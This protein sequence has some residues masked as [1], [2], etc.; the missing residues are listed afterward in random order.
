MN[1]FLLLLWVKFVVG[2]NLIERSHNAPLPVSPMFSF[3]QYLIPLLLIVGLCLVNLNEFTDCSRNGLRNSTVSTH[4]HNY[5]FI[6]NIQF[7]HR[8]Y[9]K[10]KIPQQ[11]RRSP[12]QKILC[13]IYKVYVLPICNQ[14]LEKD[15]LTY[16]NLIKVIT[17]SFVFSWSTIYPSSLTRPSCLI[18]RQNGLHALAPSVGR[19]LRL[20]ISLLSFRQF[21]NCCL[22]ETGF[23]G[24]KKCY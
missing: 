19:I 7:P 13:V 3:Y 18:S 20:P 22:V 10:D 16:F 24:L 11:A 21:G 14:V 12:V 5:N 9:T 4:C 8:I 17:L 2:C 6:E 15:S 1:F 23:F